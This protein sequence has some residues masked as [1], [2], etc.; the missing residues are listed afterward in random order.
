MELRIVAYRGL[1]FCVALALLAG[2]SGAQ[3]PAGIPDT[4]HS[5]SA[6]RGAAMSLAQNRAVSWMAPEAKNENLL[7]VSNVS[8]VTVY[9]YPS[10]TLVGTLAGLYKTHGECADAHGNVFITGTSQII[11]FAHG[12]TTPLKILKDPLY[13]PQGCSVDPLT[14]DLA[15][16]NY[17][18]SSGFD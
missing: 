10:G 5:D 15:V 12:A 8:S 16:T 7:Y 11:E 3:S 18:Q 2:C 4:L 9:A 13:D 6:S 14:G 17:D 1:P